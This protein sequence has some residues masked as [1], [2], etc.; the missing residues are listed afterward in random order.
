[1]IR[2]LY[3]KIA[4]AFLILFLV[5]GFL[6]IIWTIFA[7]RLYIQEANQRLNHRLAD[8]VVAH[9]FF[10]ED[11][12]VNQRAL[13]ES[14]KV[15]MGINPNIELYLLDTEGKV[16]AFSAPLDT[17][18]RERINIEPVKTYIDKKGAL[19]I[20]GDDPRAVGGEKV[21]SAS[22]VPLD[23]PLEG[24]LYVILGGEEFDSVSGLIERSYILRLSFWV[25]GS[26]LVF[27]FSAGLFLFRKITRRHR[28]LTHIMEDFRDGDFQR[29]VSL[30][31]EF[32]FQ[33]GDEIDR[34]ATVFTEMSERIIDQIM[35][36]QKIDD[37]RRELVTNVSHD[38]RTPLAV[39]QGYLETLDLKGERM[40]PAERHGIL[41]HAIRH[42]TRLSK[43]I[44]ELFELAKLDSPEM[45]IQ[46]EPFPLP[47][48]VQDVLLD[49]KLPADTRGVTLKTDF[50]EALP[51][52]VGDIRLVDRALHNLVENAVRCTG[53]GGEVLLS[54]S[55]AGSG[56]HVVIS[57]TGV[58]IA[59]GDLPHI[60]ERF[61]RVR[62][63]DL[64]MPETSGL[65]LAM[66]RKILELHNSTIEVES[67]EGKGTRFS[68]A[69]PGK[70]VL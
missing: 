8:Y 30:P 29:S 27:V 2:S 46:P 66:T 45:K 25:T 3:G 19:P 49:F 68:F 6:N 51:E 23:G 14:F 10:I 41:Q 64:Q 11:G 21:F 58:G 7:T 4:T 15:L 16:L 62:R 43:L 44:E 24:Y 31:A 42:T 67:E 12:T 70:P 13:E 63:S 26:A 48:L 60:F 59:A 18:V 35:G 9:R 32:K 61:Y 28:K 53:E 56:I 52:A 38:L 57:D 54:L 47:E 36:I 17:S 5:I 55:R 39:L 69:L 34:L 37:L 40:S 20:L 33:Q 22:R 50:E 65:G 1:M